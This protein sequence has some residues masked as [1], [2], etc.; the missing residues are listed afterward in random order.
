MT[1]ICGRA[2]AERDPQAQL[3]AGDVRPLRSAPLETPGR[4]VE[5]AVDGEAVAVLFAL[6]CYAFWRA[7]AA[8]SLV[9]PRDALANKLLSAAS[10]AVS[11]PLESD[12]GRDEPAR[13]PDR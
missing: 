10:M 13:G 12:A 7:Q 2:A 11:N 4:G 6:P 5:S 8:T 1:S 9:P 3:M